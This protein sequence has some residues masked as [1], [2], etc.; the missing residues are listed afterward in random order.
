MAIQ[1][2]LNAELRTRT[3]VMV[4]KDR[5]RYTFVTEKCAEDLNLLLDSMRTSNLWPSSLE[6]NQD[7]S[8]RTKVEIELSGGRNWHTM[9]MKSMFKRRTSILYFECDE[10]AAPVISLAA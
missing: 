5:F 10:E 1:S 9:F 4:S 6:T 2:N 8:G 7:F 3:M